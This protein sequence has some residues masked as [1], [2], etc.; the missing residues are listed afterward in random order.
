MAIRKS[1]SQE[2]LKAVLN[3]DAETGEFK[4][5]PDAVSG[6]HAKASREIGTIDPAGRGRFISI[7]RFNYASHRLAWLYV[8]GKWPNGNLIPLNG[9]YLDAR[10]ENL[11]EIS[12]SES[13]RRNRGVARGSSGYRGVSL[14]KRR[15]KWIATIK[16]NYR[17]MTVGRFDTK[18]EASAAYEKARL[19]AF[20]QE[21]VIDDYA[22][23]EREKARIKSRYRSLWKRMLRHHAGVTAWT[24]IDQFIAD[25]GDE[26]KDHMSLGAVEVD[27]PIGPGNWKWN[28]TLYSQFDTRTTKGKTAYEL[29]YRHQNPFVKKDR[30][31]RKDFG[32][33]VVDFNRML[34]EQDG[35]C[36]ACGRPEKEK[37]SGKVRH[38]AVDH[39]HKTGAIRGLLCGNC[40]RGIGK[41]E[42][43]PTLLR[44]AA[45]YLERHAAK[46]QSVPAL[47]SH[48]TNGKGALGAS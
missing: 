6:R 34:A 3:Y 47:T 46:Q 15:N 25:I 21:A 11:K 18:E 35:V 33:G 16:I 27:K 43:N 20:G 19:D 41:F 13:A 36:A 14:D 32:I 37:R 39:C 1:L 26:L 5:R 9:D 22:L 12:A 2:E 45:G 8:H 24:D 38:L 44:Q 17:Q 23:A 31:L 10:I 29:A 42:D 40:N 30:D 4:W 48:E 28:V 7:N